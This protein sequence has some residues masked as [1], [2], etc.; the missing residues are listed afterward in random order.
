V[1]ALGQGGNR[2]TAVYAVN[3]TI[4]T[5]DGRMKNSITPLT[6]GLDFINGLNPVSFKWNDTVNEGQEPVQHNRVHLGLIAQEVK[7]TIEDNGETLATTDIIDND[8]LV[9]EN[10]FDR[11]GIRYHALIAPM[12][13]AIQELTERIK[14]L[15]NNFV[16]Q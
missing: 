4:Q 2:F 3:G 12:I 7:E 8:A 15:E 14:Y 16:A 1:T 9:D 5:S 6:L 11:Y 10:G 13:K